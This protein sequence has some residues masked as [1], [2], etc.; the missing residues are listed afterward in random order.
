MRNLLDDNS[1]TS[2]TSSSDDLSSSSSISDSDDTKN[3][4]HKKKHH[5][6]RSLTGRNRTESENLSYLSSSAH[7]EGEFTDTNNSVSNENEYNNQDSIHTSDINM[8][9]EY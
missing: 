5:N 9:S 2:L 1:S 8:V 6:K 7:T 3:K 4:K